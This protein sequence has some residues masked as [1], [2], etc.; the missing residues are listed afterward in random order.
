MEYAKDQQHVGANTKIPCQLHSLGSIT[1]S[2]VKISRSTAG[3]AL[4]L[5]FLSKA[6]LQE[7]LVVGCGD[8]STEQVDVLSSAAC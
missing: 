8:S 4:P 3:V 2:L 6:F 5:T 7:S 1:D